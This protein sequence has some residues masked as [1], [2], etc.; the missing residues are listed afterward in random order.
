MHSL[1]WYLQVTPF[2][3]ISAVSRRLDFLVIFTGECFLSHAATS[4]AILLRSHSGT[5]GCRWICLAFLIYFN[6]NSLVYK[7]LGVMGTSDKIDRLLEQS[8]QDEQILA[9]MLFGSRAR[10]KQLEMSDKVF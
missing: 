1:S 2:T 5:L 10:E 7:Q 6:H 4:R 9:V 8:R 3:N